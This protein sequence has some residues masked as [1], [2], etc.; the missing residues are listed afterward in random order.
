MSK[1]SV[2]TAGGTTARNHAMATRVILVSIVLVGIISFGWRSWFLGFYSD[3][4][5]L[6]VEPLAT[7]SL[8]AEVVAKIEE[9]KVFKN[10][11]VAGWCAAALVPICQDNPFRWQ[12][13]LACQSLLI[14][15]LVGWLSLCLFRLEKGTDFFCGALVCWLWPLLP[16][17]FGFL[18]WPTCATVNLCCLLYTSPSPRDLS[19]SRMPSSA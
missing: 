3:D 9:S 2:I 19:T 4:Y 5:A 17:T 12:V 8:P 15:L 16:V 1:D 11:P 6:F 14:S 7:G 13:A 18:A 10:R